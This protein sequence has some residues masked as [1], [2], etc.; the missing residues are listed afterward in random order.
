MNLKPDKMGLLEIDPRLARQP[1]EKL[2]RERFESCFKATCLHEMLAGL[3]W[4]KL[5][6]R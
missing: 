6:V 4:D 5:I 3:V 2:F 1:N